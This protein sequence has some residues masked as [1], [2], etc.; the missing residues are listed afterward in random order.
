MRLASWPDRS[1][2]PIAPNVGAPTYGLARP[3]H[4]DGMSFID[5]I[6]SLG[7]VDAIASV[8]PVEPTTSI[9]ADIVPVEQPYATHASTSTGYD[10]WPAALDP[11]AASI[12]AAASA[13]HLKTFWQGVP[14]RD[15]RR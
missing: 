8:A 13:Q 12:A 6:E 2:A 5:A 10:R 11:I 1:R 3:G 4:D 7:R 15:R 9:D 14:P